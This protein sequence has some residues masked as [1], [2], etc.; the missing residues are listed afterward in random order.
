MR[1]SFQGD[2]RP[3]GDAEISCERVSSCTVEDTTFEPMYSLIKSNIIYVYIY[4]YNIY[5][6]IHN[7]IHIVYV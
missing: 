4:T 7:Y 2:D 3:C 6:Y 5:I 1:S